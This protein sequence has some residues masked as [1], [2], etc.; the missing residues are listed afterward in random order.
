MLSNARVHPT[1]PAV[2]LERAKN[3][4]TDKLGLKLVREDPGPGALFQAAGGTAIYLYLRGA[5]KADHTVA[6]FEV[7]DF[8]ATFK[9]LKSKGI[10]F[11]EY[12]LPNLK[13]KDG[14]ATMQS[15]G[16][17]AKA[18]WFKDSEGNILGIM[19]MP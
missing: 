11:E 10:V 14:V 9:E 3:F 6:A 13:T 16:G 2:N 7:S 17:V 4:Y 8:D 12:N 19:N 15:P 1:L 5:T 18:A